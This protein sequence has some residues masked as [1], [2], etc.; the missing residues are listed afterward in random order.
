MQALA[1][2]EARVGRL[3]ERALEL[4]GQL[5]ELLYD[6]GETAAA[7]EVLE[8]LPAEAFQATKPSAVLLSMARAAVRLY[9]GQRELAVSDM[10]RVSELAGIVHATEIRK[11]LEVQGAIA[12]I[13][14][15]AE[16]HR[17]AIALL[18]PTVEHWRAQALPQDAIS[19]SAF[20]IGTSFTYQGSLTDASAP[21]NGLYDLQFTLQTQAGAPVGS[22][23]LKDDVSVSGGLFALE[24]DFGAVI[25]SA[26]YQLVIGVRPGASTGAFT[27][28][29]PATKLTPAPQAQVAAVAQTATTVSNGAVGAAQIN[30]SQVQARV[31]SSCP[32]GQ[33][34]R[35]VNADGSVTCESSSSGPVGP[36]GPAGPTGPAGPAGA[37][38]PA[39]A[40][41]L[42]GPTGPT[43][44]TGPAGPAG[45]QG[46]TGNTGPA[47]PTGATGAAGS[48]DAWGRLGTA[49]SNADKNFIGTTD[50]QA[51]VIRTQN[52]RSLRIEPSSNLFGGSPATTNTI[53]GSSANNV[54]AGVRGATIAGGGL[55]TGD[56]DPSFDEEQPNVVTDAYGVIGGGYANR[57]GNNAGETTDR[58]F[59]TV[60]GGVVNVASGSG[61]TV[62]G[63][64]FNHAAGTNSAVSGGEINEASGSKST[65]SGGSQN[66]AGGDFSVVSGGS[67]NCAGGRRSWAGGYRART[68][69]GAAG[70][71]CINRFVQP[72]VPFPNAFNVNG[73]EGAFVWADSQFADFASTGADQFAIRAR[74][75]FRWGG[76]GVNST[77]SPAFTHLVA[78]ASNT[79]DGGSGVANSRTY[80]NHPLLNGN[81]NA[82]VLFSAFF[83]NVSGGTAPARNPMAIYYSDVANGTCPAGRWVIYQTTV[84]SEAL[85]NGARFNIWFVLP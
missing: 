24:L 29:A 20:A 8:V 33:S 54:S 69:S 52:V 35:V 58:P 79:C 13:Y 43:G 71:A 56:S 9:D 77:T 11:Q 37:T 15:V 23:L 85:N 38:G 26:D 57:A 21:A 50:A 74:G 16:R 6:T 67:D 34:I 40:Q 81:P 10:A 65:V 30:P 72:N 41:G 61:S 2:Q 80:L 82:V 22:V 48:A 49:G 59:A 5:V 7:R 1:E 70:F 44:L 12:S 63:G 46:L 36:Q 3:D 53:A 66:I 18:K 47:G 4:R 39:G 31:V 14:V 25:S 62:S 64:V 60:S 28:L 83:G 42:T 68:R 19:T 55:P 27:A 73:D 17:E 45:A 75:G 76:T 84:S 78:T 51:F 32:S